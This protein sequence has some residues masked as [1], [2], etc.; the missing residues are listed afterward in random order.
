MNK[1]IYRQQ[2]I[3]KKDEKRQE[4]QHRKERLKENML[5]GVCKKSILAQRKVIF[6]LEIQINCLEYK[7]Q[8]DISYNMNHNE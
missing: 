7:S 2:L 6:M 5:A 4:L 8:H 1:E 3:R